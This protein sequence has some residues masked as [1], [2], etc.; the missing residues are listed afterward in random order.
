MYEYVQYMNEQIVSVG[1]FHDLHDNFL[2]TYG[3]KSFIFKKYLRNLKDSKEKPFVLLLLPYKNNG[4]MKTRKKDVFF[5][6]L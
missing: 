5:H 1:I 6:S 2:T 4:R 3:Y